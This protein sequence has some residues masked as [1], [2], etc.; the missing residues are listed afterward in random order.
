MGSQQ[1]HSIFYSTFAVGMLPFFIKKIS[2]VTLMSLI[3][4]PMNSSEL[5]AVYRVGAVVTLGKPI[6]RLGLMAGAQWSYSY[7]STNIELRWHHNFSNYGPPISSNEWQAK[8]AIMGGWGTEK[9]YDFIPHIYLPTY[10]QNNWDLGYSLN[11]YHDD[12]GSSQWTGTLL[13]RLDKVLLAIEND[14]LV[15]G[16]SDSYRTGTL[17]LY[18]A[19]SLQLIE[20]R[21]TMYTGYTQCDHK[22]RITEDADYP[23]RWGYIDYTDCQYAAYSHG[24]SAIVYQRRL[25]YGQTLSIGGGLDDER[26]RNFWQNRVIHDMYFFPEKWNKAKNLHIP[27]VAED[28]TNY[29]YGEDQELRQRTIF[30][31]LGLNSSSGY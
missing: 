16:L 21:N 10:T 6:M 27:M 31:E 22:K 15:W 24:V 9:A 1:R 26:I 13:A 19:D 14:I 17:Q 2:L 12:I 8:M 4:L 30:W 20:W 18:Y 25:P 7:A 29:L 5:H 3:A 23:A 28:G 11:Y